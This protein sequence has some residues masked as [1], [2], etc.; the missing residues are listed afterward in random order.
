MTEHARELRRPGA[1]TAADAAADQPPGKH[2]LTEQL[3]SAIPF[4]QLPSSP[5]SPWVVKARAYN[6]EHP[7]RVAAFRA[8]TGDACLGADGELDPAQV[9][10][11][12]DHHGVSPDGRVGEQT[13]R[14]AKTEAA[15]ADQ[16]E[17]AADHHEPTPEHVDGDVGASEKVITRPANRA[18]AIRATRAIYA[19]GGILSKEHLHRNKLTEAE[20]AFKLRVYDAATA[21]L[22]D[23]IFG[24]V[25][26]EDLT[27][28]PGEHRA[29]DKH[30]LQIRKDVAG[31][32]MALLT[33]MRTAL[34]AREVVDG[35]EVGNATGIH[36]SSAYR[37]PERD[38]NLWDG[39]FDRHLRNTAK[40]REATGDPF[41]AEAL[42]LVVAYIGKRKAPPGGSNHS[43]GTAVDL[44]LELG[45]RRIANV[46][47]DQS[48]WKASWQH[49]WLDKYAPGMNF[50][51][52][53]KEA[54]HWTYQGV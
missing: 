1:A 37:S 47:E 51:P 10:R 2:T 43:N 53:R 46:F 38:R 54:W 36:V 22:G 29:G 12:Q 18:P 19:P 24:G 16:A 44:Q 48:K 28:L 26:K 30:A 25:A 52:Y 17:S 21:R 7:A 8:A 50:K 35:H 32:V 14:A 3:L 13:V 11:W 20:F 5:Q 39:G 41:G 42:R 9:A 4:L 34:Y 45:G 23:Q 31:P 49:A 27:D 15:R 33:A 40:E 6:A